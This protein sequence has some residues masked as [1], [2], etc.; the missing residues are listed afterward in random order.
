MK[1][2]TLVEKATMERLHQK[3]QSLEM[4][5]PEEA[6]MFQLQSHIEQILKTSKLSD[7][8]KIRLL[9]ESKYKLQ[10][11]KESLNPMVVAQAE[12]PL[13]SDVVDIATPP[14]LSPARSKSSSDIDKIPSE[15]FLDA[16]GIPIEGPSTPLPSAAPPPL[17]TSLVASSSS[18]VSKPNIF[19]N[20]VFENQYKNKY[21]KF[22]DFVKAH[23][24][25]LDKN[26]SGEA[27]I[28]GQTVQGSNF[29]DLIRGV[30]IKND[31]LNKL[32]V[33]RLAVALTKAGMNK[34]M[35]SSSK[36]KELLSPRVKKVTSLTKLPTHSKSLIQGGKGFPKR[37]RGGKPIPDGKRPQ[38]APP[39][40]KR[41]K[42]L[43][44][45]R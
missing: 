3:K 35:V 6:T 5:H 19:S 40:G 25:L 34:H 7:E 13:D 28:D 8:Q 11:V 32:G 18:T 15:D 45:Y 29:D 12:Q 17:L 4:F 10:R 30:F 44:L 21:D 24:G 14:P 36:F 22:K 9:R 39:P 38:F 43:F 31:R 16:S 20:L 1:K 42:I 27:V 23:P 2:M 33:P 26:A 37:K 41:P